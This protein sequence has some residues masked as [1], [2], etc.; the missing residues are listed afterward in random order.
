VPRRFWQPSASSPGLTFYARFVASPAWRGR[1]QAQERIMNY[2]IALAAGAIALVFATPAVAHH[3]GG[4]GNPGSA[5]P[6][7]T[8]PATTAEAGHGSVAFLFEYI[9][10]NPLSDP[11]LAAAAGRHEHVHSLDTIQNASLGFGLGLTN[12]LMVLVNLPYVRRTDIR[13]GHH[14]HLHGGEVLNTVDALGNSTG[15]GDLTVLGQWRFY[16]NRATNTEV[17]VLFGGTA[18]VGKTN[19]IN[20]IGEPFDAEFQPGSGAWNG[21]VGLA[22]T[23]R[24]GRWSLDSNVLYR[25]VGTGIQDTNLGDRFNYNAAVSVRVLGWEDPND[26]MHAHA[27]VVQRGT[28]KAPHV[29]APVPAAAP[30]FALDLALELNGEWHDKQEIAGVR[31]PNSGGHVVYISPGIRASLSNI[32]GYVSGISGF[33]SVGIPIVNEMNGL[34]AKPDFRVIAGIAAGF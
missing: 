5:G 2:R 11:T 12:D 25:A 8:L 27:H 7:V 29:H 28:G 19:V 13:E 33:A 16:N 20:D 4:F 21:L 15:I 14:E 6:I 1:I 34:Q 3:P 9:N 24:F 32:S 26:P 17:A 23:Q 10:L 30:V 31:D 18:P 22:F